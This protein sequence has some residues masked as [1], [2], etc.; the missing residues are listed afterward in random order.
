MYE[1]WFFFDK[2][3]ELTGIGTI[4]KTCYASLIYNLNEFPN[5][6]IKTN[7]SIEKSLGSR[8]RATS[9]RKCSMP[10]IQN[11]LLRKV[12]PTDTVRYIIYGLKY[13]KVIVIVLLFLRVSETEKARE[14]ERERG[15]KRNSKSLALDNKMRLFS[16]KKKN[17]LK[18]I[19][20]RRYS[21]SENNWV[22]FTTVD[23]I[24]PWL[25]VGITVGEKNK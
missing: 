23:I 11:E 14:R 3:F 6:M 10:F 21:L 8:L 2:C 1:K 9:Q 19:R 20:S 5:N 7:E 24:P 25:M 15:E 12:P 18:K 22:P 4:E 13:Y 16:V 17:F